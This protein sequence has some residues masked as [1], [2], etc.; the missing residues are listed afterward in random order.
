LLPE[1]AM[2]IFRIK[3]SSN[4]GVLWKGGICDRE[5]FRP[6]HT[7]WLDPKG[8][9]S[10]ADLEVRDMILVGRAPSFRDCFNNP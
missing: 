8:I 9:L 4:G 1:E 3:Y 2:N 7:A 6:R 5:H 10:M